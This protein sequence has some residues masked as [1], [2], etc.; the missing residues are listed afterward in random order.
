MQIY[1]KRKKCNEYLQLL[2]EPGFYSDSDKIIELSDTNLFQNEVEYISRYSNDLMN[3][4][5]IIN[6]HGIDKNIKLKSWFKNKKEF[7]EYIDNLNHLISIQYY[8]E[9]PLELILVNDKD[10]YYQKMDI[11]INNIEVNNY[12]MNKKYREIEINLY[13]ENNLV[14][15][16][17]KKG[18]SYND[19]DNVYFEIKGK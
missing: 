9:Y 1:I 2:Y 13:L 7:N 15:L 10:Y 12:Y 16:D 19:S 14:L 17:C 3:V 6:K 8:D 5:S 11:Y 18:I 4:T